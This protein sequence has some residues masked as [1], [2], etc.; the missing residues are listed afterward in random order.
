[1]EG[2]LSSMMLGIR[3]KWIQ[4]TKGELAVIRDA[5]F[6]QASLDWLTTNDQQSTTSW[7]FSE[8]KKHLR[9]RKSCGFSQFTELRCCL[10]SYFRPLDLLW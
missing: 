6:W 10:A 1:M 5:G 2:F 9:L 4:C 3:N 8:A 7:N